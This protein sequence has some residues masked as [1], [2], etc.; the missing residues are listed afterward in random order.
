MGDIGWI[1]VAGAGRYL[2]CIPQP[3]YQH[4]PRFAAEVWRQGNVRT[5]CALGRYCKP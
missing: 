2:G 5:S 4:P 1:L 3:H